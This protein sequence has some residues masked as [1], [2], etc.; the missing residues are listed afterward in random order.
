MKILFLDQSG[1]LGGAEL[2]LLDVAS[3]FSPHCLVG[4]FQDGPFPQALA[5]RH[6][7]YQVLA[8]S[9]IAVS[10]ESPWADGA[11]SLGQL[12]PLVATIARLGQ[13]F[14]LIYTNTS[15]A[16]ILGALASRLCGKPLVHHLRDIVSPEHFSRANRTLLVTAAN[17]CAAHVIANSVATQAAFIAAGGA[18]QTI[19]VIYN[20]FAP[21]AYQTAPEARADLRAELG[22]H[23][24]F[25][26]G[27]FSRLAPWKGQHILLEALAQCPDPVVALLVGDALFGEDDYVKG[28]YRQV[29]RLGLTHRVKFMGFRSDIPPLM[30]ACDLITHTSIAPEPFGRVIVEAM[31]CQ[32]PIVAAAAGGAVELVTD[33]ETGWL[34]PPNQAQT[35]GDLINHSY[36]H[37]EQTQA[38]AQAGYHH[39]LTHFTLDQTHQALRQLLGEFSTKG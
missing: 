2:S 10:K 35:L 37:P 39:A 15:K 19:S 30:Q 7:P 27:H 5:S 8:Q 31:L 32:R 36:H 6:I 13:D 14:D 26:V 29:Q 33:G 18:A 12:A 28:L 16:L 9:S 24:K 34:C 38:I 11:K 3:A 1:K 25:I 20:G 21:A 23:D 4:V 17:W 22:W